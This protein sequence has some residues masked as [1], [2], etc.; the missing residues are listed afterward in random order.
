MQ[1][2]VALFHLK[3]HIIIEEEY[4]IECKCVIVVT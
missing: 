1:E 2:F 4:I 3:V